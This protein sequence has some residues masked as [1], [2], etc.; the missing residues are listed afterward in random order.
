MQG[1]FYKLLNNF[2]TKRIVLLTLGFHNFITC[3]AIHRNQNCEDY[4][5]SLTGHFKVTERYIN[6]LK[7]LGDVMNCPK[8]EVGL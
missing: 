4:Q 5:D 7:D 6:D 2:P 1:R 8:C 3:Q